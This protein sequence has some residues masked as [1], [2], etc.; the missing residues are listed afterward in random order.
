MVDAA[1]RP[2]RR[3]VQA[4]HGGLDPFPVIRQADDRRILSRWRALIFCGFGFQGD[5][6]GDDPGIGRRDALKQVGAVL[7]VQEPANGWPL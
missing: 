6:V 5:V 4:H 7:A 1:V 3:T 2:A